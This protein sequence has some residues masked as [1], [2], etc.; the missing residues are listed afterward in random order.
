MINKSLDLELLE[1]LYQVLE[2]GAKGNIYLYYNILS[3]LKKET[4]VRAYKDSILVLLAT[5]MV[6]YTIRYY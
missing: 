5:T 6:Y 2:V 4:L 3:I 1:I